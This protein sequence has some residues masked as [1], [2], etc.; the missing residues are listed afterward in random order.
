MGGTDQTPDLRVAII[1]CGTS[2]VLLAIGLEKHT[3]SDSQLYESA[4]SFGAF[5]AGV[6]I[7]P[8]AQRAL[9]LIDPRAG[10]VLDKLSSTN[11]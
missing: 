4:P 9:E 8:N 2:G 11:G 6:A 7:G 10:A 1:G 5:G 3:H